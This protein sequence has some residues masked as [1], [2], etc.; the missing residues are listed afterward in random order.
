KSGDILFV[1]E[2]NRFFA[3][4]TKKEEK[5][6]ETDIDKGYFSVHTTEDA[7]ILLGETYL[8][9]YDQSDGEEIY[10]YEAE[11]YFHTLGVDEGDLYVAEESQD[12]L[13]DLKKS[14]IDIYRF[15]VKGKDP[16]K[17]LTT[18]AISVPDME[19]ELQIDVDGD[20]LYVRSIY[21][22][23]AYHKNDGENL[24][25]VTIGEEFVQEIDFETPSHDDFDTAYHHGNVYVRTT[26][27]EDGED[28]TTFTVM[29]GATGEI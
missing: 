28:K 2:K 23:S 3:F 22:V 4:D 10:T 16:E 29:D 15:N 20:N 26:I 17:L 12:T 25:H 9:V 5:V 18:P 19:E 14:I 27:S 21:G 8:T 13:T 7:V 24:W 6:W 11:G 1:E